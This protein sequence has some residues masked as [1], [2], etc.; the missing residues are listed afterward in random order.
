M[1]NWNIHHNIANKLS[2]HEVETDFVITQTV[3]Q[4]F[5]STAHIIKFPLCLLLEKSNINTKCI[6]LLLSKLTGLPAAELHL[7]FKSSNTL[8]RISCSAGTGGFWTGCGISGF[9]TEAGGGA[10]GPKPAKF[11]VKLTK[12]AGCSWKQTHRWH[13]GWNCLD[14]RSHLKEVGQTACFY[15]EEQKVAVARLLL[16]VLG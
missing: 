2:N 6:S 15:W 11:T 1:D 12:L 14:W 4:S 3:V 7:F 8:W 16:Q 10:A 13:S 5:Q 9:W